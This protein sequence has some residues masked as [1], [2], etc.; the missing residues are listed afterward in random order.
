MLLPDKR[1]APQQMFS[2]GRPGEDVGAEGVD[3][4]ERRVNVVEFVAG[5]GGARFAR[6]KK[7]AVV[8]HS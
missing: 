1:V 7:A 2:D 4:A 3:L 5:P 8:E 6:G